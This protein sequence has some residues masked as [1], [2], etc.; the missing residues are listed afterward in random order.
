M[1]HYIGYE[2]CYV[3]FMDILGFKEI[4]RKALIDVRTLQGLLSDI[5]V[6]IDNGR[7]PGQHHAKMFSDSLTVSIPINRSTSSSFLDEIISIQGALVDLGVFV[8]GAVVM[9]DHFEDSKVLFG[10]ALIEAVELEK[11]VARWPRIV[12]Q[13][14]VLEPDSCDYIRQ[15]TDGIKYLNYLASYPD[16]CGESKRFLTTHRDHIMEKAKENRTLLAVLTKYYWVANYH[17]T[18]MKA[19]GCD[20]LLIDMDQLFPLL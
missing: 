15:D 5:S 3:A 2:Q 13:P 8:R 6:P 4:I 17:N 18:E 10:P 19:Q 7:I 1:H 20:D 12:V 16:K 14:R 11:T 9:G